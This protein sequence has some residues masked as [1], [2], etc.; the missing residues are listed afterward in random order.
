MDCQSKFQGVI[1]RCHL[2]K[3]NWFLTFDAQI[4][5]SVVKNLIVVQRNAA[6]NVSWIA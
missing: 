3:A 5:T 1:L 6:H 4:A 2:K